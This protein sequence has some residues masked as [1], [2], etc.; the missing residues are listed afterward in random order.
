MG[1]VWPGRAHFPDMLNPAARRWFGLKYKFLLDQGID[2]FWNDMNEPAIFYSEKR[3]NKVFDEVAS[4]KGQNLDLDKNDHLLGLV[5]TLA[6]NP[7]LAESSRVCL[8]KDL[9][10]GRVKP[11]T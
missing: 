11:R 6:N 5:N 3:L 1:A 7:G 4:M 2:G 9:L 10:E 8:A